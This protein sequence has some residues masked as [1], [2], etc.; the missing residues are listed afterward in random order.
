[1]KKLPFEFAVMMTRVLD[2]E[3]GEYGGVG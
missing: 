1:L 2:A 3:F